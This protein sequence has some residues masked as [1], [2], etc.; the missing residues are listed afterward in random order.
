MTDDIEPLPEPAEGPSET[1][2]QT[3]WVFR[4]NKADALLTMKALGG[5]LRE[6]KETEAA[7]ELGDRL[8]RLRAKAA[9]DLLGGL[10]RAEENIGK[11]KEKAH[12]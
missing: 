11:P 8:T 10:L 7:K 6:G 4:L 1:Y 3:H 12:E 2:M 5:R 9:A